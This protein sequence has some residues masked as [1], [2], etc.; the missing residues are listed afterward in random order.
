MKRVFLS[1]GFAAIAL[2]LGSCEEEPSQ[3]AEVWGTLAPNILSSPLAVNGTLGPDGERYYGSCSLKDNAFSFALGT[4][5]PTNS[6][7][8]GTFY[9]TVSGVAGPPTEGVYKDGAP[10]KDSSLHKKFTGASFRLGATQS[11]TVSASSLPS[12]DLCYVA[13]FAKAAETEFL[14]QEYGSKPFDYFLK[15]NCTSLEV[16]DNSGQAGNLQQFYVTLYFSGCDD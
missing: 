16:P 3:P 2:S 14:P 8:P 4:N 9:M 5:K 11:W 15:I 7:P 10:K 1:C 6:A 12:D 13:L